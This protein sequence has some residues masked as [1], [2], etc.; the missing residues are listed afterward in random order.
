MLAIHRGLFAGNWFEVDAVVGNQGL[1][2]LLSN[3]EGLGR[4]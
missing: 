2:L 1:G 3:L 4:P